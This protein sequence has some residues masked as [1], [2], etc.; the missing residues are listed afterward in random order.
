MSGAGDAGGPARRD[1]RRVVL[2]ERGRLAAAGAFTGAGPGGPPTDGAFAGDDSGDD[3]VPRRRRTWPQRMVLVT[4]I[5]LVAICML[6]ASVAS[7][8]LVKVESIDRVDDLSIAQAAKGEPE[9]YLIVGVDTR[10]GQAS[11]NTDTIIVLR[12]DPKSD[13][14]ALTS[15]PRDLMVTIADTG[16]F[17][18]IN[19]AYAHDNG[20]QVLIDTIKQELDITIHHFVE[21]NW[22]SFKQVVDAVSGVPVWIPYAVRDRGSGLFVPELGC[23]NLDGERGLAFARSRKLEIQDEDGVWEQ[24]PVSDENRVRRQQIFIQRAM[25]KV[26]SQVSSN[27]LRMRELLDIGVANV[28]LDHSLTIGDM[29]DLGEQFKDFDSENL[30][31]YALPTAPWPENANRLVLREAEA[32][33]LLNVFRGLGLGEIR[34]GVVNV[35]VLNGTVA[36]E[37]QKRANLA[38]DVSGA[39]DEVGFNVGAPDDA[40]TFYAQTTL[41]HAPGEGLL[42]QRVARHITSE[43]A[44]PTEVDPNLAPGQVTLI[45]GADFTTVHQDPMPLEEMPAP[46]GVETTTTTTATPGETTTT[47]EPRPTTT[48]VPDR[49]VVG[50]PPDGREC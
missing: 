46:P 39:L 3:G 5:V 9:N 14:V 45:A 30:E 7:Y 35:T 12:I 23:V 6:G 8:T 1:R 15:L 34:A 20:E 13:R 48:T 25:A 18:Q 37:A 24:D 40:E 50:E 2:D 10:E 21:V 28:R 27:P 43:T 32:E 49:Y 22:D 47:T 41:L 44:I 29:L 33:P 17:G 42:A 19:A 38:T 31:T 16:E 36:D 26:L 4:G 11:R